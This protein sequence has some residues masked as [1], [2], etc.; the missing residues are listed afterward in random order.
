MI[1]GLQFS[2]DISSTKMNC[3]DVTFT[4]EGEKIISKNVFKSVDINSFLDFTS[5]HYKKWLLNVPCGQFRRL[6][7]N[8]A[9]N[10]DFHIQS[11]T[12]KKRFAEKNYP[13]SVINGAF[14]RANKMTQDMCI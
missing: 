14:S 12:L 7:R 3:L 13:K 8:C 6:R 5:S 9:K 1:G 10:A 11:K 2:G 4:N